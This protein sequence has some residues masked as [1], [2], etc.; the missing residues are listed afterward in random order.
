MYQVYKSEQIH[1]RKFTNMNTYTDSIITL[2]ST[3]YCYPA[4]Q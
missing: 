2:A 3:K 1:Y 4:Q